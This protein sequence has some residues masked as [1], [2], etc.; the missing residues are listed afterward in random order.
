[1]PRIIFSSQWVSMSLCAAALLVSGCQNVPKYK[2][3]GG[4]F[5]EWGTYQGKG[6]SPSNGTV[7]AVDAAA[8]TIT[9][10]REDSPM[11]Y[12][13]TPKT[14]IM[15]E[16]TDITLDKLPIGQ[17]IKFT[18]AADGKGLLTVWYGSHINASTHAAHVGRRH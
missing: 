8:N 15:H 5:D 2:R 17:A 16:G 12:S 1:M 10:K 6:F 11:V 9:I 7:L 18:L 13:V 4:K 14:R 3:S